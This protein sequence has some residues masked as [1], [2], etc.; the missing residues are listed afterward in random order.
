MCCL[1][2]AGLL[3]HVMVD[4]VLSSVIDTARFH[5]SGQPPIPNILNETLSCVRAV[6]NWDCPVYH[7]II[8]PSFSGV[9]GPA[10]AN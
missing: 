3:S 1:L 4:T 8:I 10:D 2:R 9:L 7:S 6:G 5:L